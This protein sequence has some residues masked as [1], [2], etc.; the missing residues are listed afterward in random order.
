MREPVA[1]SNL[2]QDKYGAW[3]GFPEGHKPDLTRCCEEVRSPGRWASYHQCTKPR[4][5]GPDG[6]YCKQHDPEVAKARRAAADARGKV[7]WR[8]RMLEAYG[9]TFFDALIKIADGHNDARGLAQE[10]VSDFNK[11]YP[12][13]PKPG[14]TAH[15]RR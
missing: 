11:R 13:A 2:Y 7:K 5:H 8:E 9:R 4:G 12:A 14:E 6:A 1:E 15:D 3:A 10:I